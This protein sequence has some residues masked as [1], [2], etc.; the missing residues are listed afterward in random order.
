MRIGWHR[1][2]KSVS[3]ALVGASC[4]VLTACGGRAPA[5]PP[6]I[7][8]VT[9]DT[10]RADSIG[11][12]AAKISTPSFNRVA[13]RGLRFRNG[14]A[15]VPETLPSHTTLLTGLYPAGHGIHQNGRTLDSNFPTI[16]ARLHDAGYRTAA[17]VS[18]FVLARQFGLARG[19]DVYDDRMPHGQEERSAAQTTDAAVAEL[20]STSAQ[21]RFMW[22][23]YY[24]PH[25]PYAPPEPYRSQYAS[26]PYLGEIASMDHEL[27]RLLDAWDAAAGTNAA[28]LLVADHGEGLGD[29]GEQQHGTLLYQSTMHVPL[30][31]AGSG[32]AA[33]VSDEAVSTRRVFY[34]ILDWAGL[35]AQDSLRGS[36]GGRRTKDDGRRTMDDGPVLGEAMKPFLDYGWQPQVM[37]V[38][39]TMKAIEAG[40]MEAY[41]LGADPGEAHDLGTGANLPGA[42]REAISDYPVPSTEIARAPDSLDAASRARLASLG[43]VG[44]DV[45]PVVRKNAPRPADMVGLL[46]TIEKAS[47]LFAAADYRA[48]IPVLE[49]VRAADPGNLDATLRLAV[50]Q[51]MIGRRAE[52]EA[53][54]SEAKRIAPDSPDVDVY[55]GLHY[56]HYDDVAR[57][58]PLLQRALARFPDRVPIV[59]AVADLREEQKRFAD[60]VAL[61]QK[62]YTLRPPTA[63]QLVHLGSI[64]MEAGN[65][66]VAIDAFTRARAAQGAAFDHDLDL[67]VLYMDQSRFADAR[68]A[69]DRVPPSSPDYPMAVFKRA[70]VAVLLREPDARDRIELARKKADAV[71]RPLIEKDRLFK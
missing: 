29:H 62:L 64:A 67:G 31:I 60:A 3:S 44:A 34:T 6:S 26:S 63:G 61:R 33:G 45:A 41:D 43:Y 58:E 22:V 9:L 16:A 14:Y 49:K 25:Y 17:F 27:G 21:P 69:L 28:I 20:K 37:A 8:L 55:L 18:A 48:A 56:A 10:T 39:G 15:A 65:T 51:S 66:P 54:F 59:E 47:G 4:A 23:H 12:E 19:F 7:L 36:E 68:D 70:E 38:D 13:A 57:A 46:P 32:V 53:L 24:D 30:V 2:R 40:R 50:S 71:T 35:G 1:G 42:L 11:P 5:K 52:A